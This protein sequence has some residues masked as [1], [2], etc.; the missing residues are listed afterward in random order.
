[1]KYCLIFTLCFL[2]NISLSQSNL[3]NTLTIDYQLIT[4]KINSLKLA[5]KGNL[6]NEKLTV[7]L[8]IPSGEEQT[9]EIEETSNFA[10]EL[11]TKH[12]EIQTFMGN[13]LDDRTLSVRFDLSP[14]GYSATYINHGKISIIEPKD[15]SQNLYVVVPFDETQTGWQCG[16]SD[17]KTLLD[18]KYNV[19][20]TPNVINNGAVLKT[21]RTAIATTGE[22][23]SANG[24][25]P[26]ALARINSFLNVV[27]AVYISDLAIK[28]ELIANNTAIIF[29]NPATDPFTPTVNYS[30][31][32]SQTAFDGFDA[33]N[34]VPYSS[35]DIAHT[36]HA[37]TTTNSGYQSGGVATIG[38]VCNLFNKA[39]GWTQYTAN[40]SNPA[41][42]SVVGGILTH[43]IGHQMGANHTFN[44]R[45]GN[46][47]SQLGDQYEPGSGSTIMSYFGTCNSQN[48]TS[49]KA[50]NFFHAASIESM[51]FTLSFV[52]SC[53]INT[54]L[55]NA[56]PVVN[57]GA[58]YTVP[59][60]TPFVLKGMATDAN[61]DPL[62]YT[63]EQKDEG[64]SADAGALG[65][66]NGVGGY[67]AIWSKKAPLFRT[68]Q[69]FLTSNRSFPDTTFV[70]N[71]AN[72]PN[73]NEGEDLS[74][75][76]RTMTF[77]LTARDYKTGGGG[78][79][80]DEIIV[81]VDSLK[82]PFSV[83]YPNTAI[84][85]GGGSS[86]TI[87]WA[88]N[89]TNVLSPT[90]DILISTNGGSTFTNLVSNTPN[91]GSEAIIMPSTLTNR[92]RIKI[93][94]RNSL[95]AEFY[96]ISNV[97][98]SI[99]TA[100]PTSNV[101]FSSNK[102]GLWSDLTVW[103][104]GSIATNRLPNITD[105][106]KINT[107]HIVTLDVNASIK[108]LNLIGRLNMNVG[109]ILSY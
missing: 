31:Y 28:F 6:N 108:I 105:T 53:G 76:N 39:S 94:S 69:S 23:T 29:T 32:D 47:T 97:N 68:K 25:V 96:D 82:G 79:V 80:S 93:V 103:N 45:G 58:D 66:T 40:N 100:C 81:T 49:N 90:I 48:L 26:N 67:P 50:D 62:S 3:N 57:A 55:T 27:N 21:L 72:N 42:N 38:I 35:Y 61:N 46:C 87:T 64:V 33:N 18:T 65:Q 24:G 16:S 44:G 51:L 19:K 109:R 8:L 73:D 12:P 83:T 74:V 104:C 37:N 99:I 10:P 9:F 92:G 75:A 88:V 78:T 71:F 17:L 102:S 91:D 52:S 63:W 13:C 43:E 89:N 60:N 77:S 85:W 95:T 15:L 98:F 2:T 4:S 22:F 30:P 1:M 84:S 70:L 14:L 86:Q 36:L 56:L 107:G 34:T 41:I 11:A 54:P 101:A 20:N 106:V 59:S 5:L 7:K